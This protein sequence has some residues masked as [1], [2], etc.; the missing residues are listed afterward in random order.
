MF[1]FSNK[2]NIIDLFIIW[3]I[4]LIMVASNISENCQKL[5]FNFNETRLSNKIILNSCYVFFFFCFF[6]KT[7]SKFKN[8]NEFRELQKRK[9]RLHSSKS[10]PFL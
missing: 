1:I 7:S 4:E 8:K 10:Q 2:N 3:S 6:G 5:T 9:S